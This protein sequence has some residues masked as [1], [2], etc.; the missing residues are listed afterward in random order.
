[1]T[2]FGEKMQEILLHLMETDELA[3]RFFLLTLIRKPSDEGE[4]A[5]E[6]ASFVLAVPMA[7]VQEA[8]KT[9]GEAIAQWNAASEL[10]R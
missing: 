5:D 3:A 9:V 2:T 8:K 4:D 6:Q 1:M 10:V 7:D